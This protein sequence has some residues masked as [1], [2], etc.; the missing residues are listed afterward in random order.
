MSQI[1][2]VAL[3]AIFLLPAFTFRRKP[4]APISIDPPVIG[5]FRKMYRQQW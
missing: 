2:V 3:T 4:P 1:M 5:A